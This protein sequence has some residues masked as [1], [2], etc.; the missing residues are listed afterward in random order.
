MLKLSESIKHNKWTVLVFA[1]LINLGLAEL[2]FYFVYPQ[3]VHAVRYSLWGWEHIPNIRYKFVPTSKEVVSY[4]EYNSDGF[5]GSDEYSLPVA[6]GT[7][8]LA[9]LGDSEAEGVVDY[10]YMYATVLEKLLNEHTVLSDKHAYTRAEVL[11]AGVYG[12]EPCQILRLFEARVMRY[13][14][15]I[16]YLLHNQKF[17][18]DDFC[19]LINEELVYED[20]Q[21]NDLEYYSRWIMGY[22]KAKSQLLNSMYRFYRHYLSGGTHLPDKLYQNMFFYDAP[23]PEILTWKGSRNE[24]SLLPYTK[25]NDDYNESNTELD[26][27]LLTRLVYK[28]LYQQIQSYGGKLRVVIVGGDSDRSELLKEIMEKES[29]PYF[30]MKRYMSDMKVSLTRFPINGHWNEYGN[31]LAGTALFEIVTELDA[32]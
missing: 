20:L 5:R 1:I 2:L 17:A 15:N 18:G 8:R 6:E 32:Q 16:V 21:Y 22:V 14:P 13:R 25:K 30:D 26:R 10:P 28:K 7:L 12:Y 11:K 23:I 19:R 4:I 27:Y 3:P 29:I 24:E 31:Y 9:V